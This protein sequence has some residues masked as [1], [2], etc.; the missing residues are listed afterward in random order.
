MQAFS[1]AV[2]CLPPSLRARAN[3]LAPPIR[4]KVEEIR[5]RAGRKPSVLLENQ[6]RP[7]PGEEPVSIT[8]LNRTL[9]IATQ[10]STHA[11]LEGICQGYVTIPGGHR[12]GLCGTATLEK[13]VV[14]N[15]RHISSLN[16][17]IARAIPDCAQGIIP[18]I[19]SNGHFSNTLIL[20]PPGG[21]K[22]TLLRDLVRR[23]SDGLDSP[24]LRVGLADER[25]EIAAL[26][27]GTPQFDVGFRT[28]ILD[29]C[30]KAQGLFLLLRSMNPQVLACDEIT[31]PEDCTAL[32]QCANC[33]VF[34][35][36]TAHGA[37]LEDLYR[38]PLYRRL[39]KQNL[40]EK[41]LLPGRETG[42]PP[43]LEDLGGS[44]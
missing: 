16:L 43:R 8:D 29:A 1:T 40:F 11:A 41:V 25:G 22:T 27:N 23:L 34:L 26:W 33:G 21:G 24:P 3:A 5:L 17:R 39:L 6:E 14:H 44:P 15:F 2:A 37:C 38:R 18:H 35:L 28:D 10:A 42:R 4:V 20:A 13:G 30:P 7:F 31:A 12:I 36:A 19:F 9:E 32:E